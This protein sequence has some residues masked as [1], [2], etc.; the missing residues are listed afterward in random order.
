VMRLM[1]GPKELVRMRFRLTDDGRQMIREMG[2]TNGRQIKE[3]Y[4][5]Q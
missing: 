5:R 3:I 1:K 2:L 4:D